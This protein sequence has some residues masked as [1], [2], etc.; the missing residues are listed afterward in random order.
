MNTPIDAVIKQANTFWIPKWFSLFSDPEGGFY[1][2]L[3]TSGVPLGHPRRVLS[4]C[5]QLIVFSRAYQEGAFQ[6]KQALKAAFDFIV[7]TYHVPET[8]GFKF[9]EADDHYDLYAHAFVILMCAEYYRAVKDQRALD[10]ADSVYTFIQQYFAHENGLGFYEALGADLTPRRKP[11][12]QN[13]HMHLL[14]AFL[15]MFEVGSKDHWKGAA[16]DIMTLFER[17]F[18]DPKQGILRE[19]FN[20]DLTPHD[21]DADNIEAGHHAEWI[22]LLTRY[23]NV[24]GDKQM[25]VKRTIS[26]LFSFVVTHSIDAK[27]GGIYNVQK[28]DGAIID[29]QKRIWPVME[30]LRAASILYASHDQAPQVFDVML[31]CFTAHYMD[32]NTGIWNEILNQEMQVISDY[33]PATT[34]YHIYLVLMDCVGYR[35][36]G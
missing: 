1:E 28:P 11:R 27:N 23:Q 35:N 5:R 18:F 26:Q 13:P 21:R 14:E 8:G 24:V 7:E 2:R 25:V 20:D 9:S 22:W 32:V 31:D 16:Q 3:D 36:K 6:E 29:P 15:A 10:L 19:F 4:Q 30:T 17:Y 34:P 33:L 12:R